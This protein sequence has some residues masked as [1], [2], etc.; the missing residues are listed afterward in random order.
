M[1][2]SADGLQIFRALRA[3]QAARRY[4]VNLGGQRQPSSAP[5]WLAQMLIAIEHCDPQPLP[6]KIIARIPPAPRPGPMLPSVPLAVPVLTG[7]DARAP[8][9]FAD[10]IRPARHHSPHR[11]LLPRCSSSLRSASADRHTSLRRTRFFAS[12]YSILRTAASNSRSQKRLYPP[13]SYPSLF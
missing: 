5:A 8:A 7:R 2:W 11:G 12:S 9:R 10:Q 3:A 6:G 4:V 13:I 1:A